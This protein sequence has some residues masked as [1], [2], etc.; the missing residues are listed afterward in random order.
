M[1]SFEGDT[2]DDVWCQAAQSLLMG[3]EAKKQESRSGTTIELLHCNLHVRNPR[4]RWV[5]SR[6]PGMNP[7]FAI[8]EVFWLL[9]GRNDAR[10]V[11][12]WNRDLVKYAGKTDAYHGAYGFRI[13]KHFGLD[14]IERALAALKGKPASRQVVIQI[15]DPKLDFP[16]EDGSEVSEDVPCNI[17]S[18]LKVRDGRL[19]WTQVM[20]SNDIFRGLPHN[21]VQFTMLQE[22]LAGWLGVEVGT[23]NHISDSLHAYETATSEFSLSPVQNAPFNSD[24]LDLSKNNSNDAIKG[25]TGRLEE[26]ISDEL[27]VERYKRICLADKLPE[28][29]HNLVLIAAAESARRRRW[30]EEMEHAVNRCTNPTL[31][32]LWENWRRRWVR[33]DST[34]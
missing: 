31:N 6:H 25:V 11:N 7:A 34:L 18:M 29:Y 1:K 26:L 14:Q 22:V 2:A 30:F 33:A 32:L 20:R 28:G 3:S 4:E 8:A 5:F 16:A 23:Y 15:W 13:R 10:F 17:C 24:R 19:E 21:F 12:Y 27:P 9:S